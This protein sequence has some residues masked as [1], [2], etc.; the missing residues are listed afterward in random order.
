MINQLKNLLRSKTTQLPIPEDIS[1]NKEFMEMWQI[2]S[3]K[4]MTSIE[5][6]FSLYTSTE[7]VLK[8][9]IKGDFVE[10][11][12]W[13]G[14][15]SLL[16]ALILKKNN[17]TDRNI[18]LYDTFEGM[19]EPTAEDVD[20]NGVS[21]KK[22]LTDSNIE[23]QKSVWCYSG[24]DEVKKNFSDNNLDLSKINFVKGKVEDTIP[25][26]IPTDIALLRLDTDWYTSTKHEM[27]NLFPILNSKGIL[28]I[29]DYGHWKGCRDAVDEYFLEQKLSPMINRIDYT[30]RLII[31][32]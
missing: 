7:Y 20:L 26:T 5:R 22:Q 29:D 2:C 25:N 28:I 27:V 17:I 12:V 13:K 6:M 24:I 1:S 32:E 4:S 30:G 14:G 3:T 10:C 19:S 11:G 9:N 18:Y 16:I 23:D 21:A 31:K 8:N 15:S